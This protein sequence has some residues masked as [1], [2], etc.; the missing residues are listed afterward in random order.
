MTRARDRL[1]LTRAE[2]RRELPTGGSRSLEEMELVA[3]A[4]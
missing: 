4:G 2:R 1:I 3:P